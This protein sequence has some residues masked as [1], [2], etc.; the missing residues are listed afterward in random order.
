MNKNSKPLSTK[1]KL[2]PETGAGGYSSVD[3]TVQHFSRVAALTK[4]EDVVL[5]LGAGRGRGFLDDAV[6]Y[7]RALLTHRGRCAKV[8]G[9]DIDPVVMTNP[10]LDEAHI[11]GP[12]GKI[13]CRTTALT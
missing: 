4:P 12:D 2:Y 13:P 3:G 8:I 5:D 11:I 1:E 6:P 10:S 7:R 9:A